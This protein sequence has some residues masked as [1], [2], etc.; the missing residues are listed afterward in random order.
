MIDRITLGSLE[1]CAV[2]FKRAHWSTIYQKVVS[3]KGCIMTGC[4]DPM[5]ANTPIQGIENNSRQ[6]R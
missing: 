2:S 4:L 3:E 5:S 1:I 6:V